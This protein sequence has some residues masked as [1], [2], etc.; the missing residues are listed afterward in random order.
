MPQ[1]ERA[2]GRHRFTARRATVTAVVRPVPGVIRITVGGPDFHDF[3]SSGPTDHVRLFFP[4]LATGVLTA[5]TPD[6][7]GD[8][9]VR[10]DA[11]TLNRDYTPT[12]PNRD[13]AVVTID[14]DFI[15]HVDPGPATAW[16]LQAGPGDELVVVGPRGS[17]RAP[18]DIDGLLAIVD[19]TALPSL[20]RWLA[21]IPAGAEVTIVAALAH[22]EDW[23][24]DYLT[25]LGRGRAEIV[26]RADL[27]VV[28]PDPTGDA[29][30][31]AVEELG[32]IGDRTFVFAA[33]EATALARVRRLLLGARGL[34]PEQVAASGY[35]RR[36]VVG[37]DHHQPLE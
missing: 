15:D 18:A 21:D 14:L 36:G 25:G 33:G 8:G 34:P 10:P 11:P 4:D 35:W 16:A 29:L 3:E 2:G 23:L 22:D 12:A 5:P 1:F 27:R 13:G 26:A 9:I 6:P 31:A 37:F 17:R 20:G 7:A 32:P 30:L 24:T 28:T 19:A